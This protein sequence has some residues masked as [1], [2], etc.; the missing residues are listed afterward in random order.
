VPFVAE[1]VPTVDVDGG[2][3]EVD[4][5]PGLLGDLPDETPED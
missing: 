1:L 2:V 4:P 3:V 5:P